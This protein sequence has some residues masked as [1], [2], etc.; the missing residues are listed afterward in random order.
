MANK[1]EVSWNLNDVGWVLFILILLLFF[2]SAFGLFPLREAGVSLVASLRAVFMM[3]LLYGF[4][5]FL[6]WLFALRKYGET[7]ASLGF[8][9]FNI[10][11]SLGLGVILLV[12]LKVS[13]MAYAFLVALF[14]LEP[15]PE[16][17]TGIP[18]LFGSGYLGLVLAILVTALVA[19][20]AEE[21]FFRGFVYPAF[22]KRM[23]VGGGVVVS[24]LIFALFHMSLWLLVPV[25][26]MGMV[27]AYLYEKKG[28]LGP[29]I[30]LHSLN[31]LVSVIIIYVF[32]TGG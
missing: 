8:L 21:A 20:V 14:G 24:S 29:A 13:A 5:I 18:R 26:I 19:P 16:L 15:P 31:N 27:L 30:V 2:G 28:S 1:H 4:L 12:L 32:F 7:L 17:I 11:V 6:I 3:L 22:R 25:T 10:W 23:G 9:P